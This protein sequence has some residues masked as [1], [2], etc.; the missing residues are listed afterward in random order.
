MRDIKY[1]YSFFLAAIVIFSISGSQEVKN[2]DSKSSLLGDDFFISQRIAKLSLNPDLRYREVLNLTN[3]FFEGVKSVVG[4]SAY[5]L[6][7]RLI[8]NIPNIKVFETPKV[9]TEL[10]PLLPKTSKIGMIDKQQVKKQEILSNLKRTKPQIVA[11][12]VKNL[13][14]DQLQGSLNLSAGQIGI[15]KREP[16]ENEFSSVQKN[17][18]FLFGSSIKLGMPKQK[19]TNACIEKQNGSVLF[20]AR[21]MNW[22]KKPIR[23]LKKL[24]GKIGFSQAVVRFDENKLTHVHVNFLESMFDDVISFLE[25]I[26]GT[27][28]EIT[29]NIVKPFGGQP[30][31]NRIFLWR[32]PEIISGNRIMVTLEAR[33]FDDVGGRFPDMNRSFLRVYGEESLPIFPQVST[34]ELLLIKNKIY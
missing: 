14:S 12:R 10:P 21:I 1:I 6:Q 11:K 3:R 7:T 28:S 16:E 20:C 23:K 25:D 26:H 33:K 8:E 22:Q 19:K 15:G 9:I 27:P 34:G 24:V 2:I 29:N 17:L 31:E 30:L 13:D 5:F 32:R 18:L 4:S